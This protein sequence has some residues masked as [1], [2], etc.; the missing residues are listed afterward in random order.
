M[1]TPLP[2]TDPSTADDR[3]PGE[4]ELAALYRQLPQSEP[5]PAL[6][7]AVLH[8]AAQALNE[9]KNP[10]AVER[11]RSPRERGD[12]VH[13][14]PVVV[15]DIRTIGVANRARRRKVP[16]WLLALGSAASLVVVAGLAWHMRSAPGERAVQATGQA[17]TELS[18]S[19]SEPVAARVAPPVPTTANPPA[20]T[21]V[22]VI[23]AKPS[24]SYVPAGVPAAQI[25]GN[26]MAEREAP[27]HVAE[28]MTATRT[29]KSLAEMRQQ[30]A[31]T[32]RAAQPLADAAD[33]ASAAMPVVPPPPVS[34]VSA[35]PMPAPPAAP[36]APMPAPAP[37]PVAGQRKAQIAS[38]VQSREL[39]D[40]RK[41]FADHHDDEARRR[42]EKFQQTYPEWEL[43]PDLRAHL[44]R[45]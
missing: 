37:A 10:L 24:A 45:P 39:A 29:G 15:G 42:L 14:A 30:S 31:A 38:P 9:R 19:L 44:P 3:L 7:A 36:A 22:G 35:A 41:L 17:T 4:A 20:G 16:H 34:E 27:R 43:A 33:R 40:I 32:D 13:P 2:P 18:S 12:W 6:D 8:A 5:G 23:A 25:A 1:T 28:K 26:A 21:A 11:R